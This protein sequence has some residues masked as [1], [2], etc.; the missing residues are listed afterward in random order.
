[1]LTP[2]L[3]PLFIYV[4]DTPLRWCGRRKQDGGCQ[5]AERAGETACDAGRQVLGDLERHRQIEATFQLQWLRKI[6]SQKPITRN[7]QL[8][9]LYVITIDA[10]IIPDAQP[11][12]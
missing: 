9:Q 8:I 2:V 3:G 1:M 11:G 4:T 12:E 10:Q 7:L 5:R 6:P